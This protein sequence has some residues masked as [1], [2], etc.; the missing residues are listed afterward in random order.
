MNR[1]WVENIT[2]ECVDAEKQ[3]LVLNES[4]TLS[5][6]ATNTLEYQY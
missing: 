1:M 2:F 6:R 4:N 5:G 3:T